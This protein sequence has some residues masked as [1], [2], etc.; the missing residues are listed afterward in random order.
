MQPLY[1]QA[2]CH[3]ALADKE[4]AVDTL[5]SALE[6]QEALGRALAEGAPPP[7]G[8][9]AVELGVVAVMEDPDFDGLHGFAPFEALIMERSKGFTVRPGWVAG[10]PRW[11]G[12]VGGTGDRKAL[13]TR[14]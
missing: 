8:G 2:A 4:R 12:R 11:Y 3:A 7:D 1:N 6:L 5:R 14:V 10:G 13:W 9:A